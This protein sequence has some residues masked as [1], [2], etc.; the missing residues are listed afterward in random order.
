M[1]NQSVKIKAEFN[2]KTMRHIIKSSWD[3]LQTEPGSKRAIF[4]SNLAWHYD[5]NVKHYRS[6][7]FLL[8]ELY[9]TFIEGVEDKESIYLTFQ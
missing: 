7:E 3:L 8:S 2:P 4:A 5:M 6:E 9:R 1:K